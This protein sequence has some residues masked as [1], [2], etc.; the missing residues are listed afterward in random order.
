VFIILFLGWFGFNGGSTT[1][2]SGTAARI[3]V[4]TT[5]AAC[6]GA[7]TALFV[8]WMQFKKPDVGMTLNGTLAGLVAITARAPP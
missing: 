5:L 4:N 3:I 7:I 8:S 1:A 2:G 6:A